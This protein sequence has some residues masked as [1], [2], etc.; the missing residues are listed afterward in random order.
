MSDDVLQTARD[1]ALRHLSEMEKPKDLKGM[2]EYIALLSALQE[3]KPVENDGLMDA[4]IARI[5]A[6]ESNIR[7]IKMS[8]LE[9]EID[10]LR[11]EN[12]ELLA[13]I[14]GGGSGK[15]EDQNNGGSSGISA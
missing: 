5:G 9:Q 11:S 2:K 7:D 3:D 13:K 4:V 12:A 14:S 1:A 6:I 10:I 8:D 15:T